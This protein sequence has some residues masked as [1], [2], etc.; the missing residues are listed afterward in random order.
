M[1]RQ[2]GFTLTELLATAAITLVL[3]AVAVPSFRSVMDGIALR[4][5]EEIAEDG[6]PHLL[7]PSDEDGDWAGGWTV[8][9]DA[10]DDRR[11]GE[12]DEVLL[13]RGPL[14]HGISASASFSS[15]PSPPY[16]AYN[17]GGRACAATN[18]MVAR[19]GS[20]TLYQGA[21]VRRIKISMLG[22]ARVCNPAHDR[23]CGGDSGVP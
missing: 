14:A 1:N 21:A 2:R 12:D 17:G 11:P 3:G 10:D 5:A 9:I 15:Q 16:L 18:S 20:L 13:R 23:T 7:A 19:F 8:F 6:G 4:G 22:R